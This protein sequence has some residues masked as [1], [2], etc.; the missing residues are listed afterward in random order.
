MSDTPLTPATFVTAPPAPAPEA[1]RVRR[2]VPA[3]TF[4]G[5]GRRKSSVARVRITLGDGQFIINNRPVEQYFTEL[6]DRND[7]T[8]PLQITGTLGRWNVRA[9]VRGGGHTGQ[10]GAVRLGVARALVEADRQHE[11]A[12]RDA[13][14][15]TRDSR[16]VE[17]KKYGQ[18]KARR[19][20][21]FSKR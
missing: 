15:L 12:L 9:I 7:A 11:P 19:R 5:T 17:R 14:Y 1:P 18:R 20:F 6:Q 10:A 4:I 2:G 16:R 3:G 21:Q 13:G 8:A